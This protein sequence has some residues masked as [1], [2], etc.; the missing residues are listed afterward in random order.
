MQNLKKGGP[1]MLSEFKQFIQRGN[2][3]DLAVGVIIG[4]AFG[5]IISSLVDDMLMPVI[6]LLTGGADFGNKFV[7]LK[8]QGGATLDEARKEGA[9]LAYGV[10]INN[11]I[12]FLIIAFAVFLMVK[13]LNRMQKP[14][15]EPPAGDPADVVLLTEI[16]DLL[17]SR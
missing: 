4:G 1:L 11:V 10:F 12:Q 16:R 3:M 9:V 14:K 6:G 13:A 8:G 7:P 2:V 15:E 5:K 17:K